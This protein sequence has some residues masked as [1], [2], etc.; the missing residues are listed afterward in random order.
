M[1]SEAF[2][3]M[4]RMLMMK[5]LLRMLLKNILPWFLKLVDCSRPGYRFL[6]NLDAC[7]AAPTLLTKPVD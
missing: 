2:L 7:L 4:K 1:G 5:E 3:L 6:A